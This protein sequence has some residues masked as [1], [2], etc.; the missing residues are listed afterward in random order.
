M[1]RAAI[2]SCLLLSVAT[3][4]ASLGR[5]SSGS[6]TDSPITFKELD[7]RGIEGT[8][9][10]PLGTVME[11]SGR[12]VA[13]TS[14]AKGDVDEPFFLRIEEVDG[15]KLYQPRLFSCTAMPLVRSAPDLK[16]GDTFRCIGYESGGFQGTPG[17]VFKHV[18]VAATKGFG[19][20][21]N[22]AVVKLTSASTRIQEY[23]AA[24]PKR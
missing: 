20:A 17:D 21:V 19:F 24:L 9:G 13:N 12:V 3:L 5:H 7:D 14:R 4:S 11:V 22:F 1:K 18:P 23:P 15:H 6:Q 10:H 16:V 8:L 2:G